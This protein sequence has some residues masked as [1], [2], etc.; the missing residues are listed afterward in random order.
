MEGKNEEFSMQ[1]SFSAYLKTAVRNT[2]I[3]YIKKHVKIQEA[4]IPIED[5]AYAEAESGQGDYYRHLEEQVS[6]L[7][8]DFGDV[9][10]LLSLIENERLLAALMKLDDERKRLIFW[11]IINGMSFE[12]IAARL[13]IPM[14]KAVDT[15]YNTL[16]KLRKEMRHG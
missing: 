12:E 15:Y 7:C 10:Q 16:K 4:E 11:R 2:K 9:E 5:S 14:K 3:K 1:D 8:E 13:H 6:R